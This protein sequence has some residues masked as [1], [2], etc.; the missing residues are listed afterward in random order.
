MVL[1]VFLTAAL[2]FFLLIMTWK[3]SMSVRLARVVLL[4]SFLAKGVAAH[5]LSSL[6]AL[7]AFMK[8]L[9]RAPRAIGSFILVRDNLFIGKII[10]GKFSP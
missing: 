3:R 1:R 5:W 10:L 2:R 9:V 6:A 8:V 7:E 4:A